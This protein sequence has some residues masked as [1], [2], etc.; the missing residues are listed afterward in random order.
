ML[1]GLSGMMQA[2]KQAQAI[3]GRMGDIQAKLADLRAEGNSGGGM[4]TVTLNGQQKM[5]GCKIDPTIFATHD[6]EMLEELVCSAF[7]QAQEK[8]AE[9]ISAE[10][11]SMMDGVDME[12]MQK[13]FGGQGFPFS[14]S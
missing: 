12:G 2:L 13:L 14:N 7:N 9:V 1:N 11:S 4:V 10:M 5:L 6:Q 3:R 8:L